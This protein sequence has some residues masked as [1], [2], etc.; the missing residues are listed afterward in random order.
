MA[1]VDR[2]VAAGILQ[3]ANS[4]ETPKWSDSPQTE[5]WRKAG[6]AP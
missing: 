4:A 1:K 6:N 5:A 3:I 2:A